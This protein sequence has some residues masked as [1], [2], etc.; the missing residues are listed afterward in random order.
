M[1]CPACG[2][3]LGATDPRCSYCGTVTP[4]GAQL[5][6]QRQ[7]QAAQLEAVRAHNEQS[8]Q[9]KVLADARMSLARTS[10][11]ALYWSL[12][13]LVLCCAFVPSVVGIVMGFRARKMARKYQLVLPVQATAGLVLGFVGVLAGA[14]LI[15][16]GIIEGEKREERLAAIS[17]ELGDR[18][19]ARELQHPVA[20]L[21]AEKRLL[22]GG[23]QG[24][25]S[26]DDFECD[27]K[28]EQTGDTATLHDVRFER[29]GS[30]IALK[31]CLVRGARWSTE[32]FRRDAA[33]DEADDTSDDTA[34]SRTGNTKGRA[35]DK[36]SA[37]GESTT[38][39]STAPSPK[40]Q[41]D[42]PSAP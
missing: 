32:S 14:G 37:T 17:K 25:K 9:Q 19:D 12:G 22:Q 20:C 24:D 40:S 4:Y 21:L 27:G 23:Y 36:G 6:H 41:A 11:H 18:A 31:A 15:T 13:G 8:R 2:A 34:A 38:P 7:H 42:P 35:D 3:L 16:I 30:L 26:V 1:K 29:G 5:E 28:L 39:H 10:R 33:C